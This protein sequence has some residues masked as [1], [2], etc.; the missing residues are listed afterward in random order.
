MASTRLHPP[1]QRFAA[2]LRRFVAVLALA[3]LAPA[4]AGAAL[5]AAGQVLSGQVDVG[6]GKKIPL[7]PGGWRVEAAFQ[8]AAPIAG[9]SQSS[10][11]LTTL[12]LTSAD[13]RPEIA[14][15]MLEYSEFARV[16]WT[17]QPCDTPGTSPPLVH[18]AFGTTA[19]SVQIRCNRVFAV[20]S[21]R[22][23][24]QQATDGRNPWLAKRFGPLAPMASALPLGTLEARGY[25]SR[26]NGDRL[27]WWAY[28]NT[29]LHGLDDG[30]AAL[31]R[32]P[33]PPGVR[34]EAV[35]A[36]LKSVTAWAATFTQA[37]DHDYL[38]GGMSSVAVPA[39]RFGSVEL[40][41]A[42]T[43]TKPV[44]PE[45]R[46]VAA[47]PSPPVQLAAAP[48][49]PPPARPAPAMA[50]APRLNV[51][52]L[53]IGNSRYPGAPLVNPQH[54]AN[55]VAE[56]FRRFGFR[57]T[58]LQ[59]G[60]RRQMVDAIARFAEQARN[61][62]VTLLF[63][64]GHGMQ[65]NGINYLVPVDLDLNAAR[66]A[67][68]SFEAVSLNTLLEEHMPGATKLVF[69]D[70]CRDNPLSRRMASARGGS[71]GLAPIDAAS[72]T[73]ISYST[74]DGSTAADGDDGRNSPYTKALLAH[75]DEPEDI[76]LVLRRVRQSV[77]AA[78]RGA[79][80]PWEYGSLVG[81]SLVLSQIA[82]SR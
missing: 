62:D 46:P 23:T 78:T 5:P 58:V 36:Y 72:G 73:L 20:N 3:C 38:A 28:P 39:P 7:P 8:E 48:P 53:V 27:I 60:T 79:Q 25:L 31:F 33:R 42:A 16:N 17:G 35:A 47:A 80:E 49:A 69:L 64:A 22:A 21:L 29:A 11:P 14:L 77:K 82:R 10:T 26:Y 55:A 75:L 57:V 74:R 67:N 63:Y 24:V 30:G 40:K 15:L 59:D 13:P 37:I 34:G 44:A 19:S 41:P 52:A 12:V 68:I 6:I 9:G 70:A 4:V 81:G 54:D 18:D 2:A 43:D 45:A 50:A 71:R 51:Q 32:E 65:V 66:A 1:A 76:A 56:R 61:A